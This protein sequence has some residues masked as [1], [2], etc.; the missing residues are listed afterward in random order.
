MAAKLAASG[1]R[2]PKARRVPEEA[3]DDERAYLEPDNRGPRFILPPLLMLPM[4]LLHL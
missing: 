1:R 2:P 4:F 3:P